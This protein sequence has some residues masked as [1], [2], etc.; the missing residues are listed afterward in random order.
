M[1]TPWTT[2]ETSTTPVNERAYRNEVAATVGNAE[3]QRQRQRDRPPHA[4]PY[5][6]VL[7]AEAHASPREMQQAGHEGSRR[8][9]RSAG[10]RLLRG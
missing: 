10:S 9:R 1:V 3:R 4:A 5:H 2:M 8:S 6:Q 7:P